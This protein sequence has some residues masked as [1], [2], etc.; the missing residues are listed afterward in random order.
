LLLYYITDRKQFRG[1]E[2]DW[3]TAVLAK[4]A[5]AAR[6]GVDYIQLREKDLPVRR[7][8]AL[9]R[10]A[11][12]AVGENCSTGGGK[13]ATRILINCRTDVA[14]ACAA[15][16]VHLT[17]AD[18]DPAD[19]RSVWQ[20]GVDARTRD[21]AGPIV[22]QS[23]HSEQEVM[24]TASAGADF[25]VFAPVFEKRDSPHVRP[26]GLEVLREVCRQKIPVLA[27]GGVTLEN[28]RQCAD[29]G[30]AGVAGIRLFQE[31][32]IAS[33]VRRLRD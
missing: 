18:V 26:A 6:C 25:A 12:K 23:C 2:T 5:E 32:D 10:A 7:L 11:V 29:A 24:R 4:I 9:A 30:A 20:R 13:S 27:L 3:E 17:S 16:G 14:M 19:V 21:N 31:N 1:N 8:E 15:D 28:A 33:L 22:A